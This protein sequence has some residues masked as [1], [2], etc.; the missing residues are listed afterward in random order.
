[1][2]KEKHPWMVFLMETKLQKEKME[3]IRHK[4]GFSFMFVL[5]CIGRSGG[6]A[7]LWGDEILVEIQNFRHRHIN[8]MIQSSCSNAL[9]KFTSFYGHPNIAKRH[10][11]WGLLK[12]LGRLSPFPWLC[13]R[14]FNEVVSLLKK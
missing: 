6:L 9:W 4:L 3:L 8:R 11:A 1:M 14:D 13:I 5:D 7:P 10:E 2:V 12:A